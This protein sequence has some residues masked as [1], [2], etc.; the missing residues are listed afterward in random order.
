MKN[1]EYI[2]AGAG[3]GK[4]Y[5]LTEKIVELVLSGCKM[6]E[7]IL[8]TFTKKA[9][10]EFRKKTRE[11]LLARAKTEADEKKKELL[12]KAAT[13]LDSAMIGT[14][15]SVCMQ[16]IRKYW[17]K[18][19][20]SARVT[21]M[22]EDEKKEHL[23]RTITAS[24]SEDDIRFFQKFA[25]E[26][27]VKKYD[28]KL[29]FDFWQS[30]LT[31]IIK[32]ADS[33]D[34]DDLGPSEAKSKEIAALALSKDGCQMI[35]CCV[36]EGE[37]YCREKMD[38]CIS[39]IFAIAR[40]WRTDFKAYKEDQALIEFSDM[41]TRF[42]ELL[43]DK[44]VQSEIASSITFLFVDEFQDSNPKQIKIFDKLSELVEKSYWVGD[45]KQSI[46]KFRGSDIELVRAVINK[47]D[48]SVTKAQPL[49][50]SYRSDKRLVETA[51]KVFE[52]VF[53]EVL[54][55]KEITLEPVR[56][57]HL[58]GG[59]KSLHHWDLMSYLNPADNKYSCKK[60]YLNYAIAAQIAA[61]V[62]HEHEIC[63]VVDKD[64]GEERD[65][66]PS[67]IAVLTRSG[68]G[69]DAE[70]IINALIP[71][72]I[73]IIHEGKIQ[74]NN[75]EIQ[76]VTLVL[77]YFISSGSSLLD[78]ELCRLMFDMTTEEIL[79]KNPDE[80]QNVT[81]CLD[82]IKSEVG[83][84]SIAGIVRSIILRLDLL[85]KCGKWGYQE[86]RRRNLICLMKTAE[87]Y[88]STCLDS[89][90]SAT[91]EGFLSQIADDVKIPEGFYRGGV[92]VCT[93]HKSKG[94]E[95][96]VVV[97]TGLG[98]DYTSDTAVLKHYVRGTKIV[99]QTAPT[100]ENIYSDY[101]ITSVPSFCSLKDI[102]GQA[103]EAI[104][105]TGAFIEFKYQ[106]IAEAQR[107]LYVGF[108]RARDYL[109]STSNRGNGRYGKL[110]WF[111]AIGIPADGIDA[112]WPD[113]SL[114]T[115]W[116]PGTEPCNFRKI[117][118]EFAPEKPGD[119][120][121]RFIPQTEPDK[122]VDRKRIAPSAL[123][124]EELI[125]GTVLKFL[126]LPEGENLVQ[127]V[128]TVRPHEKET[129]IGTCIHNIFAAY[130]PSAPDEDMV[131]LAQRTIAN[132]N[133]EENLPD[134]AALIRS[135]KGL[136]GFLTRE[137]GPA[138]RTEREIPFRE[139]RDGQTCVGSID[140]VW[141]TSER[142]CVLV[143]YK[144]LSR[145]SA[146]VID[147]ENEEYIGHYIPQQKAYKDA[148]ERAGFTVKACLLHLSL[149]EKVI[150]ICF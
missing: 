133:L 118:V 4:T 71:W 115:V 55:S 148:L 26:F 105:T 13:E 147:P 31:D 102:K 143:D 3:S 79:A 1:I 100:E 129:S 42:L 40:K 32:M 107:L 127:T 113:E 87:E 15:H 14:V 117:A 66:V 136:Y 82:S 131:N 88:D 22:D 56:G 51:N 146:G 142:D 35:P 57:S 125:N 38:E 64:S 12:L 44:E 30:N 16:Y 78:A 134:A 63:K 137:Y 140:F 33:F 96:N 122:T 20:I 135:I 28:G 62:N 36:S 103:A 60:E 93:Y 95:W 81:S 47:S 109:V 114:Q 124:D 112:N 7:L 49:R 101:C 10:A 92:T 104:K 11:K 37:E 23:S 84:G 126:D 50:N 61:M 76:L 108:T 27:E 34:I 123:Y 144:N 41:E 73:P 111:G 29:N 80:L 17:Y 6:S 5:N 39:R 52:P 116:G 9:A 106:E 48:G 128:K 21:E 59:A 90:Q 150:Q 74:S 141:Y 130:E 25:S 77:N 54:S 8:T 138:V 99:R 149:Q 19:G 94:L 120:F 91:I 139:I 145:A 75:Y 43:S 98:S 24:A 89:G 46:Y 110:S 70:A 53:K 58:P 2:G 65:I 72:G 86:D 83:K 67:D 119:K 18:L 132:F 69:G 121:Y 85:N 68:E 45:P 97:L